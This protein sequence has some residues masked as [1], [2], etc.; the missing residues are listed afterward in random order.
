MSTAVRS[1]LWMPWVDGLG[2]GA[3]RTILKVL[4]FVRQANP[5]LLTMSGAR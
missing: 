2:A 5:A 3:P 4:P 1:T